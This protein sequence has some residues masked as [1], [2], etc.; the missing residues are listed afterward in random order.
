MSTDRELRER[1]VVNIYGDI[2]L[3]WHMM[4][5][6]QTETFNRPEFRLHVGVFGTAFEEDRQRIRYDLRLTTV[7]EDVNG[8]PVPSLSWLP[9]PGYGV[10]PQLAVDRF[11]LG[12]DLDRTFSFWAGR[13]PTPYAGTEMLFDQDYHFQGLTETVRIEKLLGDGFQRVVPRMGLV[14]VQGYLAQN[15]IGLPQ[16][17]AETQPIYAGGQFLFDVAPFARAGS[18]AEGEQAVNDPVELELRIATGLHWFDGEEGIAPNIGVG[19]LTKTTNVLAADGLVQS[20]FMIGEVYAEVLLNRLRRARL[21]A[22]FHGLFNFHAEP[23]IAGRAERNDF[24]FDS[25]LSYGMEQL[26]QRWDFRLGARYF[27]IEADAV[28]PEFNSEILNTNIKGW[29][30]EFLVV[31]FPSVTAF[32]SV[33]L[34]EREN[35]ELNGFGK[36]NKN[37]PNR[38]SGQS[39]R[40]KIGLFLEF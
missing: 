22:W 6:S 17:T 9:F 19:Y 33:T 21:K 40:A 27:Y 13:F 14:F 30:V 3:S 38:A 37:D 26:T 24:A 12:Y 35:F 20:E 36:P 25:G 15:N 1:N 34:T 10:N 31:I 11:A 32:G 5:E 2:G 8:K 7:A 28:I 39:F 16:P 23:Q 18:A 4:F 29:Q